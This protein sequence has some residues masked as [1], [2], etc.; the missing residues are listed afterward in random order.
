[1]HKVC[2]VINFEPFV[3]ELR[4]LHQNVQQRL[5][6]DVSFG[7]S[8]ASHRLPPLDALTP[9]CPSI[10]HTLSVI[11]SAVM[12]G[13]CMQWL[14]EDG[15]ESCRK[16]GAASPP[17]DRWSIDDMLGPHRQTDRDTERHTER[18]MC[19]YIR[20]RLAPERV[21]RLRRPEQLID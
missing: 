2:H 10:I 12:C 4:S 19:V 8:N 14:R 15:A 7:T 5:S 1:M 13:A 20:E 16:Y 17:R 21:Y 9:H 18:D 3:L 11:C 6:C